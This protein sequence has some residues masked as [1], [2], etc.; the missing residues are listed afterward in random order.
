MGAEAPG[1]YHNC[2]GLRQTAVSDSSHGRLRRLLP[3]APPPPVGPESPLLN[4]LTFFLLPYRPGMT[5]T[6]TST[7]RMPCSPIVMTKGPVVLGIMRGSTAATLWQCG[8]SASWSMFGC[9]Q[10]LADCCAALGVLALLAPQGSEIRTRACSV[11]TVEWFSSTSAV[12][13]SGQGVE[14]SSP[15]GGK[16]RTRKPRGRTPGASVGSWL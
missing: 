3:Y 14:G 13:L 16:N 12:R 11:V 10:F 9:A 2:R 1:L 7:A 8:A 15:G 4:F 5:T 6:T